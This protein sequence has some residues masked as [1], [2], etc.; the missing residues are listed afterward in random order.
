[1]Y[2]WIMKHDMFK[3]ILS[4]MVVVYVCSCLVFLSIRCERN[5]SCRFILHECSI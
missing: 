2:L 5:L 3:E 4:M 1:M